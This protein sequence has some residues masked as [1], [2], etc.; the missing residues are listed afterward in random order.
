MCAWYSV[1]QSLLISLRPKSHPVGD[2]GLSYGTDAPGDL[3]SQWK[4]PR[5]ALPTCPGWLVASDLPV[6]YPS[7]PSSGCRREGDPVSRQ[8]MG[9]SWPE[10]LDLTGALKLGRQSGTL[11]TA[12][13]SKKLLGGGVSVS[14][15]G[16]RLCHTS[17]LLP[18][19]PR[20]SQRVGSYFKKSLLIVQNS[21]K[22]HRTMVILSHGGYSTIDERMYC[23]QKREKSKGAQEKG[24]ETT[25]PGEWA[26]R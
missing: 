25:G 19:S 4:E 8:G 12:L 15:G 16:G 9:S 20:H 7:P 21:T 11:L 22:R 6:L 14:H 10:S 2:P 1:L 5:S 23:S 13:R 18:G 24:R 3:S 17:S 26:P